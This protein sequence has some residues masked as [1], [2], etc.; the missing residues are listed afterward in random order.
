MRRVAQAAEKGVIIRGQFRLCDP[1][2]NRNARLLG[3]FESNGM[4]GLLLH[5][6]GTGND[7][8][9]VGHTHAPHLHEITTA[10]FA[11]NC[12][13]EQSKVS[14]FIR[15]LESY[16]NCPGLLRL[17]ERFLSDQLAFVPK[18]TSKKTQLRAI[19]CKQCM[20]HRG[21]ANQ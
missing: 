4:T 18:H 10:R 21:V 11:I 16:T 6:G 12:K 17:K 13:I 19:T 14:D 20:K 15:D 5:D 8:S 2:S 1:G 9:P 3:Q 7:V